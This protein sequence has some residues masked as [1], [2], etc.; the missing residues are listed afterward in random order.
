[1]DFLAIAH[2]SRAS[3]VE[4]NWNRHGQAVYEIFRIAHRFRRSKSRFS[5]FKETCSQGR[6]IA[7]PL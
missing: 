3:C 6:Q 5:R 2:I 4:T 7:V 1:M